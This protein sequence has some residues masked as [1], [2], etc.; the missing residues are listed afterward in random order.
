MSET[1]RPKALE[2]E[3]RGLRQIVAEQALDIQALKAVVAKQWYHPGSARGA[4]VAPTDAQHELRRACRVIGPSTATWR[5][6]R[7]STR[8]MR[9]VEQLRAHA[10]A[11]G[12][13]GYRRL[14]V[15]MAR[16]VVPL[17]DRK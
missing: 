17:A 3:N 1:Q 2:D 13:F 16:W 15:L 10:A 12:R 7:A 14:H 9:V 8:R 5:I 11:D 6:G 4:G